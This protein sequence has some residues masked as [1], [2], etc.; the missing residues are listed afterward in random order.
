MPETSLKGKTALVTGAS[1]G[2]G[3]STALK[4]AALGAHV[5]VTGRRQEALDE[6]I[7]IAEH[8]GGKVT[9]AAFDIRDYDKFQ[10]LIE[11]A[12][13][14]TGTFNIL[15]NNAGLSHPDS[16]AGGDPEKWREMMEV[17]IL[18]LLAGSQTAIRVMREGGFDGHI[19]HISSIA[20]RS[21]AS[22]VYGGTKAMV[23]SLATT[24][25]KELEDDNIRVVNIC[26]GAVITNF[27][28]NFPPDYIN[29]V[30]QSLGID[31]VFE[32][33]MTLPPE[34][35]DK[36]NAAAPQLLLHA[37]D[38][39]KAVVY[40]VTQP[41]NVDLFEITVRPAKSLQLPDS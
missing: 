7:P 5:Y 13:E 1:S 30:L 24:M 23:S 10:G 26:P 17:N 14:E 9:T 8:A 25:R 22:G 35:H 32:S 41:I 18:S 4:L 37:D 12:A 3:R 31:L 6:L 27:A 16:I 33:G 21:D 38:V 34:V 20:A 28:R 2:I 36:V 29:A 19:V 40:G 11:R 39:A 15:V